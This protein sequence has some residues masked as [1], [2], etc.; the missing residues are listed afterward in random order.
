MAHLSV[1]NNNYLSE[2]AV[3]KSI[4]QS[5]KMPTGAEPFVVYMA[6]PLYEPSSNV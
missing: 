1:G 4:A 5:S 6:A 3:P 2:K